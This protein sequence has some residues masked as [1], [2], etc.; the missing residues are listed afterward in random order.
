MPYLRLIR[1]KRGYETTYLMHWFRENNRQLS[2][3]LYVFRTP[4]GVR[5]GRLALEPEVMRQLEARH[6]E[7]DFDWTAVLDNRQ[8]IESTPVEQRRPR[9]RRRDEDAAP[10]APAAPRR[11]ESAAPS[12]QAPAPPKP[13]F[14]VP[15]RLE[16]DSPDAQIAF[17]AEWRPQI[18]SQIEQ[19][20]ADPSRR[21]ALLALAARLDPANWTDADQITTGLQQAAEALERLSHVFAKRRRRSRKTKR[22][23]AS[24]TGSA[25]APGSIESVLDSTDEAGADEEPD[26]TDSA[27]AVESAPDRTDPDAE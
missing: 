9:K 11:A 5:V 6:P 17:L 15:A 21:E 16:G 24:G 10:A 26:S 23:D 13:R 22:A 14:V 3:I 27:D 12:A 20:A 4:G 18:T 25:G 8:L 1:D 7:I 19:R 2:R